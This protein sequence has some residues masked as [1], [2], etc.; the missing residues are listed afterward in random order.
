MSSP[1]DN[2][3][4]QIIILRRVLRDFSRSSLKLSSYLLRLELLRDLFHPD[5]PTKMP[6]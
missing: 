3:L 5:L 4:R 2:I 6:V 1:L